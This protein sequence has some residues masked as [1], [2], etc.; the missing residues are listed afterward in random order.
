MAGFSNRGKRRMV[1]SFVNDGFDFTGTEAFYCALVTDASPDPGVIDHFSDMTQ[2]VTGE[3]YQD[4]GIV[5]SRSDAQ[6]AVLEDDGSDFA[7]VRSIDITY[8]NEANGNTIPVSGGGATHAVLTQDE[9]SFD[10]TIT[11]REVFGWGSF[12]GA[13]TSGTDQ[14][15][16]IQNL[17]LRL[18]E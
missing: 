1:Q 15:F 12:G 7:Y 14:D 5:V 10:L 18:T 8:T 2:I 9:G 17:E 11:G 3:G 16:V 4:G 6:W 13:K